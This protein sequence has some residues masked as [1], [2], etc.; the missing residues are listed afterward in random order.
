[1]IE[2][3]KKWVKVVLSIL[4]TLLSLFCVLP[5]LLIVSASFSDEVRLA[6]EG[7]S[8][9]P[10]G[11]T[12][13]AYEY[14][15]ERPKQ[16]LISYGVSITVTV[17]GTAGSLL[18]TGMLAYTMSRKDFGL[19]KFLSGILVF[20]LLF[21]AGLVPS[22]ILITQYY[23]LKDTLWVMILPSIIVPWHVFLLRSFL[24]EMPPSLIEAAK[25]DGANEFSIFFGIVL[26]ISKPG[27]AAVG[28][29]IAFMYWNDWY[30]ALLYVD[31][32]ILTPLQFYLY[33][34]MNS[35][36]Y[37]SQSLTSGTV[38]VDMSKLPSSTARMA[39]CVLAVA[40]MMVVFPMF[41][42]YF[43]KGLT[44]GSIKG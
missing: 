30:L 38:T 14:V 31:N 44:I 17:L 35:I 28:L 10:R 11:F 42:K 7:Y 34:I 43:V 1:M 9:L 2:K 29:L 27:F 24:R 4:M 22:Y 41:Q 13:H 19:S 3:N 33:R 39:L 16:I 12:L 40:P 18:I 23:H 5:F 37:L 32:Q 26:P 20:T 36:Q 25:I 21:S 15:L 8:F 6:A